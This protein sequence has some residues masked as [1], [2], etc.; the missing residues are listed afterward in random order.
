MP[1]SPA[2]I[3]T[4]RVPCRAVVHHR[5]SWARAASRPTKCG[6][7]LNV[8]DGKRCGASSVSGPLGATRVL[9][10]AMMTGETA[11]GVGDAS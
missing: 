6:G 2:M 8:E 9:T 11:V 5:A 4:C 7:R 1:D 3:P 10:G